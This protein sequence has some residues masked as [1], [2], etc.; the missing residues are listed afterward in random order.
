MAKAIE[1]VIRDPDAPWLSAV[2][3]FLVGPQHLR[4]PRAC[5]GA[6]TPDH[7]FVREAL[8]QLSYTGKCR[9]L[10]TVTTHSL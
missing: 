6:R 4:I 5:G 8:C 7:L 1:T 2:H 3:A 9:S 10:P